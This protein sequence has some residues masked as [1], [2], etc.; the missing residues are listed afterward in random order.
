MSPVVTGV[1]EPWDA[2]PLYYGVSLFLAGVLVGV[3]QPRNIWAVF[4]GI[5]IGQLMYMAVFLA[6]G[7]LIV[8]GI[9]FLIGYGLLSLL[10]AFCASRLR[11]RLPVWALV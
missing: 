2:E 1:V 10:G 5:V 3:F 4:I 6:A 7:P 8:L 9:I 11:N